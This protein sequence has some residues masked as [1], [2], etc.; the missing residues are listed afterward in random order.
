VQLRRYPGTQDPF[1]LGRLLRWAARLLNNLY[2][3]LFFLPPPPPPPEPPKSLLQQTLALPGSALQWMGLTQAPK[4]P[5]RKRHAAATPAA[6]GPGSLWEALTSPTPASMSRASSMI[7]FGVNA[8]ERPRSRTPSV[9]STTGFG[10]H[11][12]RGSRTAPASPAERG[13]AKSVCATRGGAQ[14]AHP[15]T[16]PGDFLSVHS[17]LHPSNRR[18]TATDQE[19]AEEVGALPA[20]VLRGIDRLWE[21]GVEGVAGTINLGLLPVRLTRQ[22]VVRAA[23]AAQESLR[24]LGG[25]RPAAPAAPK[26]AW[27]IANLVY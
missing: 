16:T 15:T 11:G 24:S 25:R 7:G 3:A 13:W 9:I 22:G 23:R 12:P 21:L 2:L 26:A 10:H 27:R 6:A 4:T 14:S 5:A 18:T 19:L 17:P 1:R 8:G 20:T